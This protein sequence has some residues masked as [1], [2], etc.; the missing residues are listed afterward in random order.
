MGIVLDAL[1]R[2]AER[3]ISVCEFCAD[4]IFV[5]SAFSYWFTNIKRLR[6]RGGGGSRWLP[7]CAASVPGV[8]FKVSYL[9]CV[10]QMD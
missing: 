2:K 3:E 7:V 5:I 6:G 10:V 9:G 1:N 8:C 4:G